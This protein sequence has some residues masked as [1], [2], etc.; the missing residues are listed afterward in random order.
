MTSARENSNLIVR[1]LSFKA[2]YVRLI[3]WF[4]AWHRYASRN[5]CPVRASIT[6]TR[7]TWP[8]VS[9]QWQ[10]NDRLVKKLLLPVSNSR[11]L[12]VKGKYWTKYY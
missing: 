2:Q 8:T 11:L 12:G 9:G 6:K 5:H 4:S 1:W 10:K 7:V 3:D